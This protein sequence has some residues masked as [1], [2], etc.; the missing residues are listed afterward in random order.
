[1]HRRPRR[2]HPHRLGAGA[3]R[4]PAIEVHASQV[5]H[6]PRSEEV[7]LSV[8]TE[9]ALSDG[10]RRALVVRVAALLTSLPWGEEKDTG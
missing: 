9:P 1:M 5:A 6:A 3:R 10:E 8:W 7:Q 4:L 2:G